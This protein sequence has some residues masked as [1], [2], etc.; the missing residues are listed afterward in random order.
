MKYVYLDSRDLIHLVSREDPMAVREFAELLVSKRWSLVYSLENII[1]VV[2]PRE[3]LESRRRLQALEKLQNRCILALPTI[4]R[5][6]FTAAVRAFEAE[7]EA[8]QIDPFVPS[9]YRTYL[10]PGEQNHQDMLV[11]YRLADQVL[12]LVKGNSSIFRHK[13]L[14]AAYLQNAVSQDRAV[15]DAVRRSRIRFENGVK[16]VLRRCNIPIPQRGI[17]KFSHWLRANPARCPGWRLFHDSYLKYCSNVGD[18]VKV[19]DVSDWATIVYLP[20]IHAMTLD[21]RMVEY[22]GAAALNLKRL[23][24]KIDYKARIFHDAT[25]WL[26][27]L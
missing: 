8:E 5:L 27:S 4:R 12:P 13:Q 23:N 16:E 20:Y 24:A 11:N 15:E 1:E 14:R 10:T 2:V 18:D 9:W 6:E 26:G 19:G 3:L 17:T 21:R 22:S 7:A 25:Q